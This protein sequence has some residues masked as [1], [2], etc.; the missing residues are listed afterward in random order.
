MQLICG[1]CRANYSIADKLLENRPPFRIQCRKCKTFIQV[2]K[3][4]SI[5]AVENDIP[6]EIDAGE[7]YE[8]HVASGTQGPFTLDELQQMFTDGIVKP[9][10]PVRAVGEK[11]WRPLDDVLDVKALGRSGGAPAAAPIPISISP[12]TTPKEEDLLFGNAQRR[13][14]TRPPM[15]PAV[16]ASA[17]ASLDQLAKISAK[18]RSA[19]QRRFEEAS[20]LIDV[21]R[22]GQ[23][24][25]SHRK[26][27]LPP[28][29]IQPALDPVAIPE[30]GQVD[31]PREAP[32][33]AAAPT[34]SLR[35]ML[36]TAILVTAIVSA[37]ALASFLMIRGSLSSRQTPIPQ[38]AVLVAPG[39]IPDAPTVHPAAPA[40]PAPH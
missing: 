11:D 17:L 5:F 38:T 27:T 29:Q 9:V 14:T 19:T 7:R 3:V 24:S 23:S 26:R 10:T 18:S 2:G 22:M 13:P 1:Q 34:T 8:L 15:R 25:S 20:G 32:A 12:N 21:F 40:A 31:L 35:S 16:D 36:Y 37:C 28:F 33:H 4:D 30:P 39:Q 6:V